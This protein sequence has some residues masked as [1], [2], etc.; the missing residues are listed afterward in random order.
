[1]DAK[2]S[3]FDFLAAQGAKQK[4]KDI[5]AKGIE[6]W[7]QKQ[8]YEYE[9]GE[10][11]PR[12]WSGRVNQVPHKT[13][14]DIC[15]T[16]MDVLL[17]YSGDSEAT[18]TSHYGFRFLKVADRIGSDINTCLCNLRSEWILKHRD[19]LMEGQNQDPVGEE[20]EDDD[21]VEYIDE[22]VLDGEYF[23]YDWMEQEFPEYI[24][25]DEDTPMAPE[26]IFYI[27]N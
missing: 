7:R 4:V 8:A 20:W 1:M 13:I 17:A 9:A 23:N 2:Q 12:D 26:L 19:E 22:H 3:Y 27:E 15:K 21:Y 14:G 18:Y 16:D 5:I 11:Q 25:N 10:F 6:E 24:H